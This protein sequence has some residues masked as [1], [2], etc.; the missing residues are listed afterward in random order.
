[1]AS[2]FV[3]LFLACLICEKAVNVSSQS[4]NY[5]N[6]NSKQSGDV[7]NR[8]KILDSWSIL[9]PEISGYD[10]SLHLNRSS[11]P[12]DFVFGVASSAYQYEGAAF[13]GGKGKS[14]WDTFS[15]TPGKISDGTNGDVATNF[16]NFYKDDVKLLKNLGVDAFKMSISWPRIL[17]RGKLSGGINKEGVAFYNNLL[18]ELIANGITPFVTLFHWD[19]PQALEDEYGGF[20]SPLII[21]DFRDFAEVCFKEFGDRIKHWMTINEA[22]MFSLNGYDGGLYGELAPGRCSSCPHGDSATEPYIVAHN[23]LLSHA[24]TFKLYKLKYQTTQKG[25]I[26]ITLYSNWFVPY[27]STDLDIKAAER[28]LEFMFMNPIVE[29]DYP[30]VMRSIVKNRLPKFTEKESSM[31]KGSF[32]FIG[33]NYYTANYAAHISTPNPNISCSTDNMVHFSLDIDGVPIGEPT[34]VSVLCVYP[35]GLHDILL[36][37]KEKYNI[38]KV[39]ITETGIGDFGSTEDQKRI[40]YY[41]DHITAV[42]QAIEKG[43]NVKGFFAWSFLDNF[44][45]ASGYSIRFGLYYVDYENGIKRIPKQSAFWFM[46]FLNYK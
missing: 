36:Y 19:V 40:D 6:P 16:Y 20:L 38:S 37:T 30:A 23:L 42:Q 14:V 33:L 24:T 29:G 18:N 17:P 27:S 25:E 12:P 41:Y 13:E 34:A 3:F 35:Q 1:M 26:G 39:Y 11:L 28:A 21:D 32:D 8:D 7:D 2:H 46:N 9:N 45:W 31:L 5:S 10:N 43:V 4:I 44:E 15:H 22:Y